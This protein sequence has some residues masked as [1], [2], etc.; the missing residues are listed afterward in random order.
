MKSILLLIGLAILAGGCA[1]YNSQGTGGI[2]NEPDV[3]RGT[4]AVS[5]GADPGS[6]ITGSGFAP[7]R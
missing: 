5:S 6:E 7:H 3:F 4:T 1:S 2:A